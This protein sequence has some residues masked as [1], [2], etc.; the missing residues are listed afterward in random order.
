MIYVNWPVVILT[1]LV[2]YVLTIL[3]LP[4]NSLYATLFLFSL[5]GFW[6]RLPGVCVA[7]P[8]PVL[9]TLDFIDIFSIIIAVNISPFLAAGFALFW[10][11]YPKLGGAYLFWLGVL[12]DGITQAILCL[13]VPLLFSLTNDLLT[14]TIIYSIAR[15]PLFLL[16]SLILPHFSFFKQTYRMIVIGIA[17]LF[18]N[19]LYTK[20]FG[21]FFSNLL[22]KGASF[23]WT[24][25][26]VATLVMIIFSSFLNIGSFRR[27]CRL[28]IRIIINIFRINEKRRTESKSQ[29]LILRKS[30]D[31]KFERVRF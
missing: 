7:E 23:S 20:L 6:S 4:F 22:S 8:V 1:S 19:S 17:V 15:I 25:F 30:I 18:V 26:F 28:I 29:D 5:I 24:L 10:N 14:V 3:F 31:D 16:I 12:K 11:V 2:L 21:D 9:Y 13:F 27:T